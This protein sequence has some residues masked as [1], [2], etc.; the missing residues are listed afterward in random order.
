VPP[1]PYATFHP[2]AQRLSA[3][4][5]LSPRISAASGRRASP[6]LGED[7]LVR[8]PQMI[9]DAIERSRLD[10]ARRPAKNDPRCQ[11][12]RRLWQRCRVDERGAGKTSGARRSTSDNAR[13]HHPVKKP[14]SGG[15][16]GAAFLEFP[17]QPL[18]APTHRTVHSQRMPAPNANTRGG[19]YNLSNGHLRPSTYTAGAPSLL[20]DRDPLVKPLSFL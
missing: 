7:A 12:T 20:T 3:N 10:R 8:G 13:L 15:G 4:G 6:Q 1:Q 5:A 14:I 9:W 11:E 2:E 18:K 16:R 19:T 17:H